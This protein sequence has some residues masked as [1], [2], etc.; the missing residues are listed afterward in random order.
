M[1]YEISY[2]DSVC[3]DL[4]ASFERQPG[5]FSC[6]PMCASSTTRTGLPTSAAGQDFRRSASIPL[7]DFTYLFICPECKWWAVR[8]SGADR[9]VR[10]EWDYLAVGT[11]K[12]MGTVI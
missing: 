7:I 11:V 3:Y 10:G 12:K 8:E 5:D 1:E 4:R 6:C 2:Q 9:E